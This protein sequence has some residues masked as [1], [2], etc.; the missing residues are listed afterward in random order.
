MS[1]EAKK[2]GCSQKNFC[3]RRH[4]RRDPLLR[5]T[6]DRGSALAVARVTSFSDLDAALLK[7]RSSLA[8]L[9]AA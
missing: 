6:S 7:R 9:C 4:A 8:H 5:A 2:I 3:V 1:F